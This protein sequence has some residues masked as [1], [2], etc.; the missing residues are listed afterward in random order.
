MSSIGSFSTDERA[1][2]KFPDK[3][4]EQTEEGKKIPERSGVIRSK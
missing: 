3:K 4:M 2:G 1:D